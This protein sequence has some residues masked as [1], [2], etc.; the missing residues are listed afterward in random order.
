MFVGFLGG[1]ADEGNYTRRFKGMKVNQMTLTSR[2]D[3]FLNITLDVQGVSKE[4][5]D[6]ARTPTY[7]SEE[8]EYA[9]LFDGASV[10]IKSGN[11]T[12]LGELPVEQFEMTINHNLDTDAYRLGSI[13]RYALDEGQTELTGSLTMR[14]GADSISGAPLN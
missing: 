9:Y 8:L 12:E 5:L 7:P 6:G 10:K 3:D 1:T 14:A 11:M 13:E 4:L 2:V